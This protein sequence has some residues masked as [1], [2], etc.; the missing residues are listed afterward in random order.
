MLMFSQLISF[1]TLPHPA[2]SISILIT[3][4]CRSS[5]TWPAPEH[6]AELQCMSMD[7]GLLTAKGK[8]ALKGDSCSRD[9][10][11]PIQ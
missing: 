10:A 3:T 6:G 7:Q 4:F 8:E 2:L 11:P 5:E 9:L 1:N